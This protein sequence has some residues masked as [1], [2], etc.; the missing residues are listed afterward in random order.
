MSSVADSIRI[1]WPAGSTLD[2]IAPLRLHPGPLQMT[3]R[4]AGAYI[5]AGMILRPAPHA[6]HRRESK[7]NCLGQ[8]G[9]LLFQYK[10]LAITMADPI[11]ACWFRSRRETF[12]AATWTDL[13]EAALMCG[14]CISGDAAFA[15]H[16]NHH[17]HG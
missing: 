16:L 7:G 5:K 15:Q 1:A 4:L 14:G 12:S 10:L 9:I 13:E 8:I 2:I 11:L 3:A 17:C 6:R